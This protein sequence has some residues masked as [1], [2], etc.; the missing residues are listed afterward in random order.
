MPTTELCYQPP[1]S[2]T[3]RLTSPMSQA[4][5]LYGRGRL[6]SHGAFGW[7]SFQTAFT[8]LGSHLLKGQTD[9][10][11]PLGLFRSGRALPRLIN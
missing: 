3:L 9:S 4:Y 1:A 8:G 5:S 11:V 2:T 7:T 6:A 10:V